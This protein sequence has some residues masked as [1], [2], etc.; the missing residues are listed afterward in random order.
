MQEE[1]EKFYRRYYDALSRFVFRQVGVRDAT[2]DIVQ[3]V[4]CLAYEKWLLVST[5]PKQEGWLMLVARYK[6]LE[7]WR[8][9][10]KQ[11]TAPLEEILCEP[12]E[13]DENY[14]MVEIEAVAKANLRMEEWN[15]MKSYYWEEENVQKLA[16][17]AGVNGGCM[18]MRISRVT[19]KLR[20]VL[21]E[22]NKEQKNECR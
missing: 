5:H 4:F 2:E 21:R 13:D 3:E 17:Q 22:K 16:E 8:K 19:K 12:G 20:T 11:Q 1:F 18:R 15:L 10:E 6:L 14:G 7:Y 9:A